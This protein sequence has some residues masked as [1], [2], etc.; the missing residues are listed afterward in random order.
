[1]L[2]PWKRGSLLIVSMSTIHLL[3]I[4]VHHSFKERGISPPPIGSAINLPLGEMAYI[5]YHRE[6]EILPMLLSSISYLSHCHQHARECFN[7]Q[8][9]QFI[10][11]TSCTS[12]L[13]YRL[14]STTTREYGL[15][16]TLWGALR[17]FFSP[18]TWS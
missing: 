15:T 11:C 17:C 16:S 3:R 13:F 12:K 10:Q 14:Q 18:G 9:R 7:I 2:H 4:Q 6:G 1:M 5:Y 8:V